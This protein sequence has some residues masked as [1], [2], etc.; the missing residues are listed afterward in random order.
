LERNKNALRKKGNGQ[1]KIDVSRKRRQNWQQRI[2]IPRN[3]EVNGRR[4]RRSNAALKRRRQRRQS[5]CMY[6]IRLLARA[7]CKIAEQDCWDQ[8]HHFSFPD[9]YAH[10]RLAL[11]P[12][13]GFVPD[14]RFAAPKKFFT[15]RCAKG[16]ALLIDKN[17]GKFC[18]ACLSP[19]R[20]WM[21]ASCA[22]V[23]AADW[24]R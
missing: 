5:E 4:G 19:F 16:L 20:I 18:L 10:L 3:E 17:D 24:R 12:S 1:R 9:R 13:R 2:G 11:L 22:V 21:P 6:V 8:H 23:L 15:S 14:L 7:L